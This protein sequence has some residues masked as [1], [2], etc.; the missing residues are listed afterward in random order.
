M[1]SFKCVS[2]VWSCA[3]CCTLLR[4]ELLRAK[5]GESGG[6]D[7]RGAR[8]MLTGSSG[9]AGCHL[10]P[11]CGEMLGARRFNGAGE[12]TAGRPYRSSGASCSSYDCSS[13]KAPKLCVV[14]HL[15]APRS[16][17]SSSPYISDVSRRGMLA[18]ALGGP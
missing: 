12:M 2:G 13:Y 18:S 15:G 14:A 8:S 11:S 5:N 16:A 4:V 6:D 17:H 9:G 7:E 1:S 10:P 3:D